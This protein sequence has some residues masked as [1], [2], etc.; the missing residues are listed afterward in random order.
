VTAERV[1]GERGRKGETDT[2]GGEACG[3]EQDIGEVPA[4]RALAQPPARA[5]VP[6]AESTGAHRDELQR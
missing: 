6:D 4:E 3:R 1:S 5:D 2:G